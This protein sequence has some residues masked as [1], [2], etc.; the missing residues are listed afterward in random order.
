M[1]TQQ[2]KNAFKNIAREAS[3]DEL[4][5]LSVVA[6]TGAEKAAIPADSLKKLLMQFLAV[7][8]PALIIYFALAAV[9]VDTGAGLSY[10]EMLNARGPA[11]AWNMPDALAHRELVILWFFRGALRGFMILAVITFILT[12]AAMP[13]GRYEENRGGSPCVA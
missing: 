10:S 1:K 12:A 4:L 5:S 8:L 6:A 7:I 9:K 13:V 3:C 2:I 11:V